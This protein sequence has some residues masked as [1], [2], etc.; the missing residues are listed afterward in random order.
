[1]L[2][3]TEHGKP[4]KRLLPNL[5]QFHQQYER[6]TVTALIVLQRLITINKPL[7]IFVAGGV[8]KLAHQWQT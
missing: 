1:M 4:A 8:D 7:R 2:A 3:F 6:V 5:I